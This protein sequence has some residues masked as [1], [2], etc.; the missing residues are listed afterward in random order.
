MSIPKKK[1]LI[2]KKQNTNIIN[3]VD[4]LDEK[5]NCNLKI[6]TYILRLDRDDVDVSENRFDFIH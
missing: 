5:N 4:K 1:V 6:K 2:R 3:R